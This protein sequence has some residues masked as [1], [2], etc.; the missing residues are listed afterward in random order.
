[1]SQDTD[2]ESP[3][4]IEP[5]NVNAVH[6]E[7]QNRREMRL[8]PFTAIELASAV[9]KS[10]L[11]GLLASPE[12]L[13]LDDD[14]VMAGLLVALNELADRGLAA[15]T[16]DEDAS[17]W[18]DGLADDVGLKFGGDLAIV[19]AIRRQPALLGVVRVGSSS[20]PSSDQAGV[21]PGGVIA[22]LHGF[23]VEQAGLVGL[24][25]ESQSPDS[26]HHFV[27]NTPGR[28]AERIFQTRA[29]LVANPGAIPV[30]IGSA[31]LVV[32]VDIYVP[33]VKSPRHT[34]LVLANSGSKNNEDQLVVQFS[35]SG[36]T[37]EERSAG[38][39]GEGWIALFEDAVRLEP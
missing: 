37:W 27:L 4:F 6:Q 2:A 13:A 32:A 11:H 9:A 8:M 20:E 24:L 36:G 31:E 30:H 21:N 38:D 26:V 23:A 29:G 17:A 18:A 15:A 5:P 25:E 10:P 39:A 1:M 28:Q 14:S 33:H 3:R 34:R 12:M 35:N 19:S 16:L 22:A 7:L